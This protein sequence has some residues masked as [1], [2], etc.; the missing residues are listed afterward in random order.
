MPYRPQADLWSK[1]DGFLN[2]PFDNRIE[3]QPC[4]KLPHRAAD[5]QSAAVAEADLE[6]VPFELFAEYTRD[7]DGGE[8]GREAVLRCVV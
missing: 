6:S 4:C 3:D 7:G 1:V 2:L 8:D 5:S